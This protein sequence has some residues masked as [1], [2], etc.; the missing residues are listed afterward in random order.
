M[1]LTAAFALATSLVLVL[2]GLFVYLRV[3]DDLSS[4]IDD[5]LRTRAD[6]VA[7][8]LQSA[9]PDDVGI[10]GPREEGGE[11]ILSEVVRPDGTVVASSEALARA[12]VLDRADLA[13]AGD[14]AIFVDAGSVAG[15]EGE[16]RL[17]ARPVTTEDGSFV[18]VTGASTGDRAETLSSLVTSF[19]VG[20]LIALLLASAIGY[21]L[22]TLAFRPVEEM[23][24]RAGRITLASSGERLPIPSSED[25]IA[26]LGRT[27]NEMLAR[28][29]TSIER[30]RAFV[31]DAGH[32]LRTPLAILRGE[33]ELGMRPDRDEAEARAAMASAIDEADRLQRLADDLLALARSD[34]TQLPLEL[35]DV[36]VA[37]LLERIRA[38][39]A[40]R[41]EE[42][43][44]E[45]TVSGDP[46]LRWR[47]DARRIEI[48]IGNLIENALRH[49]GGAIE[50][51]AGQ[52][53]QELEII[54]S[55]QGEGFVPEFAERAF[56][57]FTRAE[58][59]RT[60]SGSGLG[61]AIVR[62]I[63]QA[64]GGTAE[65][66]AGPGGKGA[67]VTMRLPAGG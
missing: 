2:V 42:S 8:Q 18:I 22:A 31:A 29:E 65:A 23:R 15:I 9:G 38:R 30:E 51:Q 17:F 37:A 57:R 33:L 13:A 1:R 24:R 50:V 10:G 62:A 59:G 48:A 19:V 11:D 4:S 14:G 67:A 27:L 7:S 36:G 3:A 12:S 20:G 21:G 43:G 6:D 32:E 45:L 40:R 58:S 55:D 54:V 63:A 35:A 41:V 46:G 49:G 52:A 47:L 53:G 61:L 26:R 64:H 66:G 34:S 16:A 39:F 25:E 60:T 44:R 56:D 5:G 28:I